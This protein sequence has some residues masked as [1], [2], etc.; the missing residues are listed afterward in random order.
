MIFVC[1]S[2]EI[3]YGSVNFRDNGVNRFVICKC[4]RI[5]G[6]V[7]NLNVSINNRI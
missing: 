1:N 4:V 3:N 5:V 2:R 7:V 6:A